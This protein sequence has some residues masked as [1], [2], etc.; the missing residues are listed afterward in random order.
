MPSKEESKL[1]T[2]NAKLRERLAELQARST[3]HPF[4]AVMPVEDHNPDRMQIDAALTASEIRYRRLFEAAQDGILIL[5]A[6][7]GVIIDSNPY[8]ESLLGYSHA[9]L[10]N[11]AIWEIGPFR[12]ITASRESFQ[13]LQA[14]EYSR[15]ENLPLETKGK[16]IR[17]VEFVSNVYLVNGTRVIQCNIRDIT[18]RRRVEDSLRLANDEFSTLVTELK[19]RDA[20][21]QS[22][23]RMN[24]LLQTCSTQEEAYRVIALMAGEMFSGFDGFLAI[25]HSENLDF[26]VISHRSLAARPLL[27]PQPTAVA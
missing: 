12:D 13:K 2:E 16:D 19:K 4:G 22:L 8:L 23:F 1:T 25:Q 20:G 11:K 6:D 7:S 18:E 26:E 9:E 5:N 17:E 21:M 15:Y 14:A 24:D 27:S 3:A 10:S